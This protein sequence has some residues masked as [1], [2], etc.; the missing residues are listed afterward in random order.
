MANG[1]RAATLVAPNRIEIR[2]YAIPDIPPDGGLLK[3]E[4]GGVCGTDYKY[5]NGKLDLPMPIILGHEILGRVEKLGRE[6]MRIHGVKE[7][8]RVILKGSL[9]CGRC[10]DCRRGF[11]RFCKQR[12]AYGSRMSSANPPHLFGGFAEYLYLTPTALL[13]K[14]SDGISAEAAALIGSVM[15]NGFQW[16]VRHGG[17]K[18]GDYVLIQGP[19]QQGL[20]CTFAASHAGAARIFVTGIGRDKER[21]AVA[22]KFGAH[23]TIDVEQE[24]P[25]NVI[26]EETGGAMADVAVDVSGNPVA[27]TKS[28]ECLRRQGK[29]VIGG[30]TGDHTVTSMVTDRLVWGEIC[31]QGAYT[32]D[33]DAVDATIRLLEATT[34]P[35]EEMVSHV[36]SLDETEHCIR[37]VGGEIPE[38]YPTKALIKPWKSD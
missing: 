32:G 21:L 18:M 17:V 15:A 36:F 34:F 19:G 27:I 5:Y 28:V 16:A 22:R 14:I 24:D 9:G 4:M 20:A 1:C 11:A 30:L 2:E 26:R 25:A 10:A 23:R 29:L 37:A 12:S 31:I 8:D 3:V 6:A 38:L 33:N 35:V 7:G 13:T